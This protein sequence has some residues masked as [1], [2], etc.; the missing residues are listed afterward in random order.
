MLMVVRPA[1]GGIRQHLLNLLSCLN[2]A[3]FAPSLAAPPE[4]LHALPPGVLTETHPLAIAPRSSPLADFRAAR[5]LSLLAVKA[6]LV[7]AHGLRAGWVTTL[8]S[9]RRPFPWVLSA[10]NLVPPGRATRFALRVIGS[11]VTA[12]I[13]ISEAI[14]AGLTAQGI[15]RSKIVV[16]PNGIDLAHFARGPERTAARQALGVPTDVFVI[17][18]IARL[19]PEK[20]LDVLL[21]AAERLPGVPVLVAGDG[22]DRDDLSRAAPPNVRLIGRIDDTRR[23]LRAAD[24]LAVPSRLEGQGIVALEA[25]ASGVPVVASRVGG[26]AEMLADDETALLVPPDHPA[27]LAHALTRLQTD[28]PLRLRLI[29]NAAALVRDRY[30]LGLM[31]QQIEAVYSRIP[32]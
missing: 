23:L 20:G 19:S 32:S 27:A 3:Q 17:G 5:S 10:H 16:I 31:V 22:P 12:V 21:R 30:D 8:A 18:C 1:A 4:F 7:H 11:R 6:D 13:A 2:R 9:L 29:A 26:L 25:M 24:A 14:A 28:E 15:T